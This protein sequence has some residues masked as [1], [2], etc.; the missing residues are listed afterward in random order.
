[1]ACIIQ[2]VLSGT[3]D[4]TD[5]LPTAGE[6]VQRRWSG[7]QRISL[8]HEALQVPQCFDPFYADA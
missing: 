1:M 3:P 5:K 6:G 8:W 4:A 7:M 2:K